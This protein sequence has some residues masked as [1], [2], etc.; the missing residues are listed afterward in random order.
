MKGPCWFVM[1]PK[2]RGGYFIIDKATN[3][4]DES[5]HNVIFHNAFQFFINYLKELL[6]R[7]TNA[8]CQGWINYENDIGAKVL[9]MIDVIICG[10]SEKIRG[11]RLVK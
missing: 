9:H 5:K 7:E 8:Q 10:M 1:N 11:K 4:S 2:L 3:N 6:Q